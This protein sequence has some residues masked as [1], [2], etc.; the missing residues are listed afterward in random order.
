MIRSH[1]VAFSMPDLERGITFWERAFNATVLRRFAIPALNA[2]AAF[3]DLGGLKLELWQ[4]QGAAP[5][6]PERS[7][8]NSDLQFCG[9]KHLALLVPD[10]V[11]K[12]ASLAAMQVPIVATQRSP[13]EPMHTG[14]DDRS[15]PVFAAFI[16]DPFGHL[17]ELVSP[18]ADAASGGAAA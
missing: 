6:P 16:T 5:Q 1:H 18:D 15:E 4:V 2:N 13:A 17:I 7:L 11:G 10:I 12:L 14:W 9:M 3:L 8:P